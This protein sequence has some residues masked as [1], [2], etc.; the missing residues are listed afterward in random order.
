MKR[1]LGSQALGVSGLYCAQVPVAS[2]TDRDGGGFNTRAGTRGARRTSGAI[3]RRLDK[4][5]DTRIGR[6]VYRRL[7]GCD[8]LM[9][10]T[11]GRRSAILRTTPVAGFPDGGE[12]W[13]IVAAAGGAA[14][15]PAWYHN[16]AARPGE[17][18]IE[19]DG[20]R[21][22]VT[23]E[24]LHGVDRAMAWQRI[25][26]TAPQFAWFQHKTDRELP[27]IRLTPSGRPG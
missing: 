12:R 7:M 8:T 20:R 9:L 1:L 3:Q 22:A 14:V 27:V 21:I 24:Q 18:R 16:I 6:K 25:T 15:N 4:L 5:A 11:I 13:L 10:T 23:A 17:V 26:T 2:Q 19:V